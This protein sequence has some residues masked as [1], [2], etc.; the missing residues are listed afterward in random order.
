MYSTVQER[1]SKLNSGLNAASDYAQVKYYPY[2]IQK[3]EM[4][5]DGLRKVSEDSCDYK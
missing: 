2:R 1:R 3:A 5:R 4:Q